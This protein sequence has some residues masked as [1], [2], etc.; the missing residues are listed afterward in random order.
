MP[1]CMQKT[2][3]ETESFKTNITADQRLLNLHFGGGPFNTVTLTDN[4]LAS[5][6]YRNEV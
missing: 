3:N 4:A 6:E 1:D 2:M 5:L